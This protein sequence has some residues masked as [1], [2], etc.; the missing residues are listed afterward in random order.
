M[1]PHYLLVD[2]ETNGLF[3]YSLPADAP[4]QPRVAQI[5]MIFVDHAFKIEAEHEFLVKPEGW[6]MSEEASKV[7]GLTTE[8]L[9]ANGGPIAEA[10]ALY[11]AGIDA[12]RVIVGHNVEYDTKCLRGENRRAGLDDRYMQ[13]RTIC[14][15]RA[16]TEICQIP[17]NG[18]RG[19]YK[20]PK[21]SE[22]CVFFHIDQPGGHTA[23]DDARSAFAIMLKLVERGALPDPKSPYDRVAK[24]PKA[25]APKQPRKA[26]LPGDDAELDIPDVDFIG[27]ASED[28]K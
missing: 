7:T 19:G 28:G 2:V 9:K 6:E 15:M 8:F 4:G 3:N 23:L 21:L 16:S 14:T 27:G 12:R 26:G 24:K 22:A 18:N 11:N 10:L 17:P 1:M 5:G 13:T 20:W 25:K